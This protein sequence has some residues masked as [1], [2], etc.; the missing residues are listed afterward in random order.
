MTM[1]RDK[2]G[3]RGKSFNRPR[4]ERALVSGKPIAIPP[5]MT[6]KEMREFIIKARD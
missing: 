2:K 5:G 6:K 4:M 3:I 1:N